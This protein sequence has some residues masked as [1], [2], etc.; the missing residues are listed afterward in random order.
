M[1]FTNTL[2]LQLKGPVPEA[3]EPPEL[4][5]GSRDAVRLLVSTPAG[6]HHSQFAN[7]VNFLCPGDLLVVNRS[8]TIAA[9]LPADGRP[10]SFILNLSSRYGG[11]AHGSVWLAEPRWDFDRPGPL[12][13]G[14][15]EVATVAGL[16]TTFLHPYPELARLWFV[17]FEGDVLGAASTLGQP[18]RYGY[19][20]TPYGLEHYQTLFGTLPGSAE[21][22]SASRPFTERVL[23]SL[24]LKDVQIAT[25][26]LHTG[27]SSLDK[28]D[29]LYPE[30]FNVPAETVAAIAR[31]KAS[32]AR[33]IAVGTTVVRAV[34][35][36]FY[37]GSL[38]ATEGFTRLYLRPGYPVAVVDG[39]ITGLHA[40][41]A[42]HLEM[43]YALAGE[44]LVREAYEEAVEAGYLWHEFGDS[45]LILSGGA[46]V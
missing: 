10:G 11:D 36:A 4:R 5:G 23:R 29:T 7:L 41:E 1:T 14:V 19:V 27:V 3:H 25:I 34:E 43:L 31:A 20:A 15:G 13:L 24:A 6:H 40:P 17:R 39:L 21:M 12:P 46:G 18:I 30:P 8:A 32:G 35:S 2:S 22:P 37:D 42:S 45:H 28:S 33:V 44:T 38:H 26:T 9:S 16:R